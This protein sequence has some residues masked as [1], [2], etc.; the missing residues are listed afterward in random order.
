MTI[1]E[2]LALEPFVFKYKEGDIVILKSNEEIKQI[3]NTLFEASPKF[4]YNSTKWYMSSDNK[5]SLQNLSFTVV[6]QVV[7]YMGWSFYGVE[8]VD[9]KHFYVAEFYL[10]R[11]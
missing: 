11:G 9:K 2:K 4:D 10:K 8:R 7:W 5:E 3:N 1:E 6:S